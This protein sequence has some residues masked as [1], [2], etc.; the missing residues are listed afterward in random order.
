MLGKRKRDIAVVSRDTAKSKSKDSSSD[1]AFQD[2]HSKLR[3]Y[4][5]AHFEPLETP[6]LTNIDTAA[7]STDEEL[8]DSTDESWNGIGDE[9]NE[10]A[11]EVVDHSSSQHAIEVVDKDILKSFMVSSKYSIYKSHKGNFFRIIIIHKSDNIWS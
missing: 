6:V 4:F 10:T 9:E 11:P 3:S 8:S 5:E 1:N 7:D 2:A